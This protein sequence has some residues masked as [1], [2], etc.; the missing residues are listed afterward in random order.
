MSS[1]AAP[2]TTLPITAIGSRE[3]EFSLMLACC[4]NSSSQD[5]Q[6]RVRNLLKEG[7]DWALFFDLVEK[8]GV[9]PLV[10]L[11]LL[12]FTDLIPAEPVSELRKKFGEHVRR[13]LWLT[14]WLGKVSA[15]LDSAGIPCLPYKG[16]ILA[17]QLYG[18]V[19][20]RQF[21]DLDFIVLPSD[22]E[23]TKNALGKIGLVPHMDFS[24]Q[25]M[26]A[27]LASGY[28]LTF[29]GMGNRNMVEIQWRVLPRFYSIDFRIEDLFAWAQRVEIGGVKFRTL[30]N[31]DLVL[32]LCAHAAK[33]A[34]ARLSWI[35]DIAKL[36]NAAAID[37]AGVIESAAA[38]GMQRILSTSLF[39][40][41]EM[42]GAAL[43]AEMESLID[44]DPEVE[45]LGM[46]IISNISQDFDVD[47][48]STGYFRLMLRTRE[49]IRDRVRFV[50]RLMLTPT[51]AEW[52]L[53]E[54]PSWLFPLYRVVRIFRLMRRVL[55]NASS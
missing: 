4:D 48:E 44:S 10:Q 53:I 35:C 20:M 40:I 8:H 49:R 1:A 55:S 37:W 25:E 15:A 41:R 18:D 52:S 12:K 14:Q 2:S 11:T 50:S 30:G 47:T 54:L 23:S 43:P 31:D 29:D 34:W 13:A 22:L 36:G 46:Q 33:H 5:N 42:F 7:V 19:A 38:L 51:I 3:L 39:L 28:E 27:L 17:Q 26:R 24:T 9:L 6:N 16:P 32:I 45:T 21:S